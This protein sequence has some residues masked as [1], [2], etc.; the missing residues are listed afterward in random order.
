MV[1]KKAEEGKQMMRAI[2]F[3]KIALTEL[4]L[5]IDVSSSSAKLAFVIVK[6]CKKND[7]EDVNA[8]LSWEKLRGKYDPISTPS[9]VKTEIL[10]RV[11]K[12]GKDEDTEIWINDLEYLRLRLESMASSMTDD[13]FMTQVLS[14]L[15]SEYELQMLLLEK[16]MG[17]KK[18]RFPLKN[19]RMI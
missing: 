18:T 8:A 5:S 6:S 15:A 7:F 2:E 19:S 17:K 4:V 16:Y 9:L 12:L 13:Q 14:S 11:N 3:N 10:F 1:E